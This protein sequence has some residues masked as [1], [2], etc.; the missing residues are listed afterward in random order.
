MLKIEIKKIKVVL[1]A[2]L[3][4]AGFVGGQAWGS[5]TLTFEEWEKSN[6]PKAQEFKK[7][8]D[9]Q[10]QKI[11]PTNKKITEL[12]ALINKR[13]ELMQNEIWKENQKLQKAWEA[14]KNKKKQLKLIKIQEQFQENNKKI[15][16]PLKN[17]INEL[18]NQIEKYNTGFYHENKSTYINSL[19]IELKSYTKTLDELKQ[20]EKNYFVE[21]KQKQ[22]AKILFN[23]RLYS[24]I[25]GLLSSVKMG[26]DLA[27]KKNFFGTIKN[28]WGLL[29]LGVAASCLTTGY[30]YKKLPA[31]EFEQNN[32]KLFPHKKPIVTAGLFSHGLGMIVGIVVGYG[33]RKLFRSTA[34]QS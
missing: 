8:I 22:N 4:G 6:D 28:N 13:N 21:L 1:F 29:G 24:F 17:Q 2:L 16:E 31:L 7:Q 20:Q 11:D 18:N 15:Y 33:T 23:S 27:N 32:Q 10:Q 19:N 3:L 25:G 34:P 9:E 14:K 30:N 12:T 26:F 5:K